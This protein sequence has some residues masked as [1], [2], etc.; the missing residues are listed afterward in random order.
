MVVAVFYVHAIVRL[1][2]C[3][4]L[5]LQIMTDNIQICMLFLPRT[6]VNCI[7][8]LPACS[9]FSDRNDFTRMYVIRM[10]FRL[11]YLLLFQYVSHVGLAFMQFAGP[12]RLH[13]KTVLL[14]LWEK[15]HNVWLHHACRSFSIPMF[16]RILDCFFAC[17]IRRCI[18]NTLKIY[19]S[20][21]I[22]F[23][24][25]MKRFLYGIY[26]TFA[27]VL[28]WLNIIKIHSS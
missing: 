14:L 26:I 13:R 4:C 16:F 18:L 22:C 23:C 7:W 8:I 28:V 1:V 25:S 3:R 11:I 12:I 2:A 5:S 17:R 10:V 24:R 6:C 21:F 20:L 19:S 27:W 15:I 9:G